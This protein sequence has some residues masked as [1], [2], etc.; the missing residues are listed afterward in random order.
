MTPSAA[1]PTD[2]TACKSCHAGTNGVLQDIDPNQPTAAY[3]V[4][5]P[6]IGIGTL[7]CKTCHTPV[8]FA[9][10]T[11][12]TESDWGP[13]S[14]MAG[15]M[16]RTQ[17]TALGVATANCKSCHD[18][19]KAAGTAPYCKDGTTTCDKTNQ[20]NVRPHPDVNALSCE[21]CHQETITNTARTWNGQ[22]SVTDKT[23][24]HAPVVS[25]W[26]DATMSH[27]G[28]TTDCQSCHDGS[29]AN[30][31]YQ[32]VTSFVAKDGTHTNESYPHL[33]L[34][35][36]QDCSVFHQKTI[37]KWP[38]GNYGDWKG[39]VTGTAIGAIWDHRG[40]NSLDD[41]TTCHGSDPITG[42]FE[43]GAWGQDTLKTGTGATLR[44]LAHI[45][46]GQPVGSANPTHEENCTTCHKAAATK[47][48][49][50]SWAGAVMGA[51]EHKAMGADSNCVS[52]HANKPNGTPK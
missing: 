7:D 11:D 33:A 52:C 23:A 8:S 32:V 18:G 42:A 46:V 27:K 51:V 39:G 6:H 50:T 38:A 45:P 19:I 21:S 31:Q 1:A 35:V 47:T 41:C 28:V 25:D 3:P 26:H 15:K 12:P 49:F 2:K 43:S 14:A 13:A 30:N 9:D 36:P 16:T 22:Y 17:H 10:K 40:Q 4:G 37:K 48:T 5:F 20:A 24:G 34:E 44:S 29:I